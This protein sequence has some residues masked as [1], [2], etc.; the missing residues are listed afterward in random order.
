MGLQSD[1]VPGH[2]LQRLLQVSQSVPQGIGTFLELIASHR[3]GDILRLHL[4]QAG[5]LHLLA[6]AVQAGEIG[7]PA[8]D[9]IRL[10]SHFAVIF[11]GALQFLDLQVVPV[12]HVAADEF[13]RVR[14]LVHLEGGLQRLENGL[15]AVGE[16]RVLAQ[17]AVKVLGEFPGLVMEPGGRAGLCQAFLHPGPGE[18]DHAVAAALFQEEVLVPHQSG[19]DEITFDLLRHVGKGGI[20][21]QSDT[22]SLARCAVMKVQREVTVGLLARFDLRCQFRFLRV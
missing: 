8:A 19:T 20:D 15:V 13:S 16:P 18:H 5:V 1:P 11:Q 3:E 9:R 22:G 21:P 2:L 17:G 6:A 7:H 14:D 4:L 12:Q 10:L